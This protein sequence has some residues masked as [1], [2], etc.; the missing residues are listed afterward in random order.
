MK[1]IHAYYE[2]IPTIRQEEEFSCSNFWKGS[3][4]KSGWNTL[5]LNKTHSSASPLFRM[6]M[7]KLVKESVHPRIACRFTRWCAL[8]A[9]GGGWMS[10][11]DVLNKGFT[12]KMASEIEALH[13]LQLVAGAGSYI[14]YATKE[15]AEEVIR[16]FID[17]PVSVDGWP[18]F[19]SDIC[20][21]TGNDLSS[22]ESHWFHPV[23]DEESSRSQKM[24]AAIQ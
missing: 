17:N 23:D 19:E 7:A 11:Y 18:K 16:K 8:H 10:D 13:Q 2:S 12:P 14:F 22:Y 20:G 6:L 15:K 3:W 24:A 21:F 9:A 5:M 1:T 4:E